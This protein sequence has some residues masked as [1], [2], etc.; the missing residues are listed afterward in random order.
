MPVPAA[1]P[2]GAAA[3]SPWKRPA[4]AKIFFQI[5]A[6]QKHRL[7]LEPGRSGHVGSGGAATQDRHLAF[8]NAEVVRRT[9]AT[10]RV[11]APA[12]PYILQAGD[13][14]PAALITG[15][16]SDLRDRSPPGDAERL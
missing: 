13:G 6:G 15:I 10:D 12:S 16:R 7:A 8:L 2:E 3:A 5:R 14:D 1:D 4:P 11:T 9:V